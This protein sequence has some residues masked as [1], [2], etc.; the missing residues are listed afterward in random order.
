LPLNVCFPHRPGSGGPGSFQRRIEERFASSG[1]RVSY[2]AENR[3]KPDVVLIVG[4]TRRILRLLSLKLRGVPILLRLDG[5]LWMHRKKWPGLKKF[6]ANELRNAMIKFT[7]A[8]VADHVVYQS[9]FVRGWWEG[10]GWRKPESAGVIRNG[11]DLR[12]FSPHGAASGQPRTAE[13]RRVICVEGNLDYSPYAIDLLNA[14]AERL[15]A[16]EI[17][18]DLYGGFENSHSREKLQDSIRYHGPVPREEIAGV[19]RSGVY[20]SLDVNAACPNAV[21]EAMSCGLPVVGFDTGALPELVPQGCGRIVSY[22]SD[23]W[24]LLFPDVSSLGEA[25]IEVIAN[26]E[27]FSKNALEHARVEFGIENVAARYERLIL[28]A[29]GTDVRE[30]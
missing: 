22:G 30:S 3:E 11:V 5:I 1:W 10:A 24:Q 23:P 20:L 4:G 26:Y 13:V 12:E 18:I 6:F 21:I 2:F 15:A 19:Y 7:H 14:L 27:T 28:D 16:H 25:I 29:I 9:D 17:A 8:F